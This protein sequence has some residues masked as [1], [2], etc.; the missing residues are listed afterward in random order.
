MHAIQE[1]EEIIG[2]GVHLASGA[3]T[4]FPEQG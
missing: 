4:Q 2:L 1:K 3:I